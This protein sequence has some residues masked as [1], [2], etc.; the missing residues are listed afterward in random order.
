VH[1]LRQDSLNSGQ[2]LRVKGQLKNRRRLGLAGELAVIDFVRPCAQ[3]AGSLH[4]AQHIR[5]PK[6]SAVDQ[7]GLRDDCGA[8]I[9]SGARLRK[10]LLFVLKEAQIHHRQSRALQV[11]EIGSL[12]LLPPLL[13]NPQIR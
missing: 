13:E 6:P 1:P 5:P 2:K 11:C 10:G 12:V 3:P 7:C 9:H 8:V 4:S